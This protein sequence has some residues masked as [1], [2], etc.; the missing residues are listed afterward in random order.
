[1]QNGLEQAIKALEDQGHGIRPAVYKA[2]Y[3]DLCASS[4]FQPVTSTSC[5]F[6]CT[7]PSLDT[8]SDPVILADLPN[9][10]NIPP[11]HAP[12]TLEFNLSL[13]PRPLP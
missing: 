8:I 2:W 9:T 11:H 3:N 10:S 5:I 4:R 13:R 12:P 7:L 6:G 1:M